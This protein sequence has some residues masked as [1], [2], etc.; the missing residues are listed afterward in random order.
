[1][2]SGPNGDLLR[3]RNTIGMRSLKKAVIPPVESNKIDRIAIRQKDLREAE[4]IYLRIL[5][6]HS[7]NARYGAFEI[8]EDLF[9]S[10]GVSLCTA[11]GL[12]CLEPRAH[13]ILIPLAQNSGLTTVNRLYQIAPISSGNG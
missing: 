10:S 7:Y 6:K 4:E 11:R 3:W 13:E 2:H 1:L 8:G 12:I 9:S 5:L